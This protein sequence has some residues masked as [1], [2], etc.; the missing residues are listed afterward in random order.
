MNAPALTAFA[1][2]REEIWLWP[3]AVTAYYLTIHDSWLAPI[4]FLA[5]IPSGAIF[6]TLYAAL[7]DI[8]DSHK[9]IERKKNRNSQ[10]ENTE[11]SKIFNNARN[12]ALD[13][14]FPSHWAAQIIVTLGMLTEFLLF[15]LS[16]VWLSMRIIFSYPP[17]ITE[18]GL[19][20]LP[21]LSAAI[22][23]AKILWNS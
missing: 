20:S 19:I 10:T 6:Y 4:L 17:T 13:T 2:G 12:D 8:V 3:S 18:I 14:L 1:Q 11:I 7:R 22:I 9:Q 5:S 23:G 15:G 21:I 16:F